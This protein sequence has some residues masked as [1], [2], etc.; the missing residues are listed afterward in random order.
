MLEKILLNIKE[1]THKLRRNKGNWPRVAQMTKQLVAQRKTYSRQMSRRDKANLKKM[2]RRT[3]DWR[4]QISWSLP[5]SRR[6]R[7]NQYRTSKNRKKYSI[8]TYNSQRCTHR[9][10]SLILSCWVSGRWSIQIYNSYRIRIL[11]KTSR[12]TIRW[13]NTIKTIRVNPIFLEVMLARTI[14]NNTWWARKHLATSRL[15]HISSPM[16][17]LGR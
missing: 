4:H 17:R 5:K 2:I 11:S 1:E 12:W 16:P 6:I 9:P 10:A 14:N 15:T 3:I 7:W 13:T 8:L